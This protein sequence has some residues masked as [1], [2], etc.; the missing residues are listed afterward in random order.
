LTAAGIVTVP[1]NVD[2]PL[3]LRL[4]PMDT[5]FAIPI[6]PANFRLAEVGELASVVFSMDTTPVRLVPPVTPK[7]PPTFVVP[8]I[9]IPPEVVNDPVLWLDE[10]VLSST[11]MELMN[12]YMESLFLIL[13]K[14]KSSSELGWSDQF[15]VDG[16]E[17]CFS[18]IG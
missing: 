10:S 6:P 15:C 17:S 13:Q 12:A 9:P 14:E 2:V 7:F 1:E 4:V 5:L 3:T 11:E 18:V 8:E 16:H